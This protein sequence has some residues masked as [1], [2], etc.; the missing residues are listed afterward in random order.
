MSVLGCTKL[1]QDSE[2]FDDDASTCA[3][4]TLFNTQITTVEEESNDVTYSEPPTMNEMFAQ[5]GTF[6]RE[7]LRSCIYLALTAKLTNFL[8]VLDDA[9]ID[10]V[11]II[12]ESMAELDENDKFMPSSWPQSR[13]QEA[14]EFVRQESGFLRQ[15]SG[16][17]AFDR[18]ESGAMLRQESG[19]TTLRQESGAFL[20]QKSGGF[21]RQESGVSLRKKAAQAQQIRN[22][23]PAT[24]L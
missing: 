15:E 11:Q 8:Q 3:P 24:L 4:S 22:N 6:D 18:Q 1:G 2:M 16:F 13:R 12:M 10:E 21:L 20:R 23:A 7:S 5:S 19:Y 9:S 17:G 14:H